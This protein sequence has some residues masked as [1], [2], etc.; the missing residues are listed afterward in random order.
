MYSAIYH[1]ETGLVLANGSLENE[2]FSTIN[3]EEEYNVERCILVN[4]SDKTVYDLTKAPSYIKIMNINSKIDSLKAKLLETDAYILESIDDSIIKQERIW[5]REEINDLEKQKN[6]E[7][8]KQ[9]IVDNK[10][11]ILK[12]IEG[13]EENIDSIVELIDKVLGRFVEEENKEII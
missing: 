13:V 3:L 6:I 2:K 1:I 12:Y 10:Y 8:Y 4:H 9:I 5:I 7:M 11:K